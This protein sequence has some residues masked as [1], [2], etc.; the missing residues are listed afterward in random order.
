[1]FAYLKNCPVHGNFASSAL[2]S[3]NT[4]NRVSTVL[5]HNCKP[6]VANNFIHV[7]GVNLSYK[8]AR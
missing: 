5:L 8:T 7:I 3:S 6:V 1:M 2:H 4:S